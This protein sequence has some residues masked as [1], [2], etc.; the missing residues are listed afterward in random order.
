MNT[1]EIE[2]AKFKLEWSQWHAWADLERDVRSD[3]DGVRVPTE[4]G[5]YEARVSGES[6][7]LTIGKA[8]NLRM[9]VKQG[10][11]KGKL[12]HS[13]GARIRKSEETAQIEVRW[14]TT[15]RPSCAEEELHRRYIAEHGAL[16][17]YTKRT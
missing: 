6:T 13:S 14:A 7:L 5:V 9:R 12:P 1:T 17:K 4:P 16:P 11:V 2:I 10:L 15:D 3:A 8:A